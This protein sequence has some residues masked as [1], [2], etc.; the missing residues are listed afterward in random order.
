LFFALIII[1][2]GIVTVAVLD[3][4]KSY[5]LDEND[6]LSCHN[7]PLLTMPIVGGGEIPLYV[8]GDGLNNSAHRYIDCTTCHTTEPHLVDTPLTKQSLA[9]KCGTCHKYEYELH[10][11]SIHGE[12]LALGNS[13]VAT[14]VDCH[15]Q[16][17]DPHSMIR[18]LEYDA[19]AYK[20]NIAGTCSVC[21]GDEAL[22][23][24]YDITEKIYESYMRSFHGKAI[25]LG[26]YEITQLNKA[27][28]TN[29]HGAHN[30]KSVDSQDSPVGTLE[31]LADT[32]DQCHPS[33]GVQ[34]ASGF[35]GHKGTSPSTAPVTYYV[36]KFFIIMLSAIGSFAILLVVLAA[37]RFASHR[38]RE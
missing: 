37:I 5:A 1:I 23:A 2:V 20:K 9:E 12:Q 13:D 21:H 6:C 28:C 22:M 25:E 29:C 30:I 26:S 24:S 32:C 8:D 35:L 33:A 7:D 17:R 4:D 16:N 14:C 18:V 3:S 31:H 15:S 10:L 19:P 11:D 27:T 36:E 34:F 38:W